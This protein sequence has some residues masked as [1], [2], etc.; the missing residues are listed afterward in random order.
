MPRT[1]LELVNLLHI[2]YCGLV[3]FLYISITVNC[4]IVKDITYH[5]PKNTVFQ[6]PTFN[7]VLKRDPMTV[8]NKTFL[9]STLELPPVSLD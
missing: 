9:S 8:T 7:L 6:H 5:I 1:E 4:C 3:V 2:V